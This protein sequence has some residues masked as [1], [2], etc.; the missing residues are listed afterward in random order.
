MALEIKNPPADAGDDR[1]AIHSLGLE[2]P[3]LAD[4]NHH[5]SLS[6]NLTLDND[7]FLSNG[8]FAEH[9]RITA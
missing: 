2:E 5:W 9:L 1:G 7:C 6:G 8:V 3:C 4:S